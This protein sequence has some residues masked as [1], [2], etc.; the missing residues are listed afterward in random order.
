MDYLV[1]KQQLDS[2]IVALGS[3]GA[4]VTKV[5]GGNDEKVEV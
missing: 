3:V 4:L 5:T 2:D 1:A